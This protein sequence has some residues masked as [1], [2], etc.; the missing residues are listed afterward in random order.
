MLSVNYN[1]SALTTYKVI[2][3]IIKRGIADNFEQNLNEK[4]DLSPL[5]LKSAVQNLI[6]S[7]NI[8]AS[9]NSYTWLEA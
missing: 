8:E 6:E 2:V 9:F 7:A 4:I 1:N 3:C 5:P